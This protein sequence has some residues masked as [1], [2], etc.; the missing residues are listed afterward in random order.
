[1][2]GCRYLLAAVLTIVGSATTAGAAVRIIETQT[3]LSGD[4]E[5]RMTRVSIDM[6]RIRVETADEGGGQVMIFRADREVLWTLDPAKKTYR[7][8]TKADLERMA[9][10]VSD[11]R[12]QMQE[13]LKDLPPDRRALVESMMKRQG[14][15]GGAPP[16]DAPSKTVY[17]QVASNETVGDW[18]CDRYEGTRDGEQRW[19]VWTA[20]W[21]DVGLSV[22]DFAAFQ[23][24][25]EFFSALS[26]QFGDEMLQVGP[27]LEQ[28][29][30]GLPVRRISYRDGAPY[31]QYEI[32]EISDQ[33]FDDTMFVVPP[34]YQ[35]LETPSMGRP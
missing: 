11:M 8:M 13:R 18:T 16:T 3:P 31:T 30:D 17:T 5:A 2:N 21:S 14:M 19:D 22:D 12:A 28:A 34:D 33:T 27:G 9:S 32:S 7:E 29:Y 26:Q 6:Q 20:G 1:M 15:A 23:G 10:R 35:K 24:L 4:R 25:S